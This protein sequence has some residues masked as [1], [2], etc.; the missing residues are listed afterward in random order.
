MDFKSL[1][2]QLDQLNEAKAKAKGKE[3]DTT[4]EEDEAEDVT[5]GI[6]DDPA[7]TDTPTGRIHKAKPGGYGRRDDTDDE[8]KKVAPTVKRGR[9]RPKKD[10]DSATGEVNKPDWS[11]FGVK[12]GKDVK[13]PKWDKSKTTKHSLKEW[14]EEIENK[15]VAEAV[16][17]GMKPFAVLDPQNKQAGAGVVTSKNPTVQK[18]LSQLDPKDVQIVMTQP[19]AQQSSNSSQV[20]AAKTSAGAT[21]QAPAGHQSMAEDE[22]WIQKA[23]KHPGA[24][25]KK[26]QAAGKSVAAFAKEKAH[27]PGT[28][29]KQA[30]LAQT[31]GKMHKEDIEEGEFTQH[32]KPETEKKGIAGKLA[33]AAK[34]FV[35]VLT[36]PDDEGQIIDLQRKIGVPQ[37]GKKPMAMREADIPSDQMDMGAGLGAGRSQG[38]AEGLDP[39]KRSRLNDLIDAYRD[40]TDPND[41]YDRE[42]SDPEEVIEIIRKEFGDKIA[43][44][45][46]S[47]ADKM[48]FSRPGHTSWKQD[49]LG[50][51]KPIDRITK[52]GKMYKQDSDFRKNTI[53]SRYKLSGKSATEGVAEGAKPD[54]PDIDNDKNTTEPISK[55]AQDAKKAKKKVKEGMDHRLRAAYHAGK[56]H[57]LSKMGYNCPFEDMEESRMYHSGFKEGLDECYGQVA[58][59]EGVL[60]TLGGAALGGALGG[61]VGA[62]VGAV[63]GQEMSKGGSSLFDE[64]DETVV[65]DMAS[66][67]AHHDQDMEEGNAFTAA[68]A[69][70]PQGGKFSVGGKTFTDRSG[71]DS[72]MD[73]MAFES[74]DNQL[75]SLLTEGE[76][77]DE[78]MT[79]S[80]S[81]GQQG[82]P[83]SVSVSAQDQDADALLSLIKQAGLGLFG[84][85]DHAAQ[86]GS[87]APM[88]VAVDGEPAEVGADGAEIDVVDDHDGMMSLIKKMTGGSVGGSDDYADEEGHA[89]HEHEETCD[90]C[91]SSDCECDSEEVVDEVQSEDQMEYQV[92]EDNPPDS[93]AEETDAEDQEIA[94]DNAAA[95]PKGGANDEEIHEGGDGGEASEEDEE[96]K[97]EESYAN[98]TDD[99]Y[100]ADINFI[101]KAIAGGLNKEKST[102]QTTIPVIAGQ[103]QRTGISEDAILDWK[104]LAGLK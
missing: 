40:S 20:P 76:K 15:Y 35:N 17:P 103:S 48:H 83:D 42:Y 38:V 65:D 51:K 97:V 80:I 5:E 59:D 101:M 36:G 19:G 16:P 11:A 4:A 46:E 3:E 41:Y 71:Y 90:A 87:S 69:R 60:G 104:K 100:E 24:F 50:W 62:A 56:S 64:S 102:G 54:F 7:T 28:L 10:A 94:A 58:M 26:A 49:P 37:T 47:G 9:G 79:V 43:G 82:S 74:W 8:G 68:L 39:E 92:A 30:R 18:M 31:L 45:V 27:A 22:K 55:A 75:N 34:K 91:G 53:K 61:P 63:G 78:G 21:G 88:S 98:S 89:E 95:S 85:D 84:G 99:G 81:K 86:H 14:V 67:G 52:A 32:Y 93:G 73:E 96:E 29:G 57:A 72:K 66:F 77:V 13:L 25:T 2:S 6:M 1:L 23:V 12:S 33:G 70:T 44:Q